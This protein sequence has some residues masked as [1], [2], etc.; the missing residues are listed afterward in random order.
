MAR[1]RETP[2]Q[3]RQ[4]EETERVAAIA[5]AQREQDQD[6]IA[7]LQRQALE[8]EA[9]TREG[10]E[11]A[12]QVRER[13]RAEAESRRL[14]EERRRRESLG[15]RVSGTVAQLGQSYDRAEDAFLRSATNTIVNTAKS[16]TFWVWF[17]TIVAFGTFFLWAKGYLKVTILFI[18]QALLFLSFVLLIF[19]GFRSG[20]K[21]KDSAA[22]FI[23][24]AFILWGIDLLPSTINIPFTNIAVFDIGRYIGP[25]YAGFKL[26]LSGILSTN[27]AAV[28]TSALVV[29]ALVLSMFLNLATKHLKKFVATLFLFIIINQI[30]NYYNILGLGRVFNVSYL[31]YIFLGIVILTFALAIFFRDKWKDDA[32]L[33]DYPTYLFMILV[34]SFFWINIGWIKNI[35]ALLH[36]IYILAFGFGYVARQEKENPAFWHLLIPAMLIADFYGYG[37]LWNSGVDVFRFIPIIVLFVL[38]YC[39]ARANST[40][41]LVSLFFVLGI[42]L[43]FTIQTLGVEAT[44][45]P[46]E[47]K[48][49]ADYKDFYTQFKDKLKDIIEGQL[50][51]A[52]AGLYRGSV[53]KNRYESLGVYFGNIRAADP[54]FYTDEP[55]TVWGSI[56]SKTYK[57]AVIINFSCYR[58]KDNRKITANK[59][60]PDIR[61]PIFTLEEVDTECTFLPKQPKDKD[62]IQPGA[63]TIT[64][65]AEYNFGT[66]AYLKTYF[67]DKERF[68]AN[69]REDIDHLTQFGIK[70]KNP[71]SVSTN[72]PVEIGIGAGPLVTVSEGYAV[73]PAVG[74]TLTNR[75]E[76]QDKDKRIIT[77]WDGK[78]KNITELILLTPPGITLGPEANLDKCNSKDPNEQLLCPCSMPFKSY[79]ANKCGNT[80]TLQVSN[81]CK[82]VCVTSYKDKKE[83]DT[84]NAECDEV[85]DRCI[86]ECDFL[87]KIDEGEG[88]S[89]E[90]YKGYALDV[91]SLK[92]KDL[93]KDIDKHRSFVCRFEPT[94]SVLGNTPITTR[95]FRVRA[96]YNYVVENSVTVNVEQLPVE[97]KSTLPDQLA[98]TVL[99]FK[100]GQDLWFD[101]FSPELIGAIASVES[102]GFKHCCQEKQSE[103]KSDGTYQKI[104]GVRCSSSDL[105]EC[106][107]SYL[108]TSGSSYGIMQIN[109]QGKNKNV[110]NNL[111][112]RYCNG[113][114]IKDYDC[115]VKV[116][117]AI[118]KNKF[119]TFKGGCAKFSGIRIA[120]STCKSNIPPNKRYS[121][122]TGIEA[123]LR[124]YNGWGC[125]DSGAVNGDVGYVEKVLNAMKTV[126]GIEIIDRGTLSGIAREGEGMVDASPSESDVQG[127]TSSTSPE[128]VSLD[129]TAS[130]NYYNNNKRVT[131]TWSDPGSSE[132]AKYSVV[133]YNYDSFNNELPP[134]PICEKTRGS[135]TYNCFDDN[136]FYVQGA[137]NINVYEIK[138]YINENKYAIKTVEARIV[139]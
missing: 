8:A 43:I 117:I 15:G 135:G 80:C 124:G 86:K 26:D 45:I 93:N 116:G 132:V 28:I 103:R 13:E 137:K 24:L 129:F 34:F 31:N 88:N 102:P 73:K 70:D 92:F 111:E 46:F 5:R 122:Y 105:K 59:I 41:A 77:K 106:D 22:I 115:N 40:Y 54:R 81:P 42:F 133:R 16:N 52:T 74:I 121:D 51:I 118:L 23:A 76:I 126:K 11:R 32:E 39:Y 62:A 68:R 136:Q 44:S 109:Y 95:Y 10:E 112:L 139:P 12:K 7:R 47:A 21:N 60:I 134:T 65:S 49:G 79:D 2:D 78:I 66:D 38:F 30:T 130:A 64:F 4:R 87:F 48:R 125:P 99:E 72:G 94:Q 97:A 58:W 75:K 33:A 36:V 98:K 61:F 6:A 89:N 20:I 1:A 18:L 50:D 67:I 82:E 131:I 104:K 108:V 37:L 17:I 27:W 19:F 83:S 138:A 53:E 90:K 120:C 35:R 14:E 128:I 57:D 63:N 127:Q 69:A 110:V 84:C 123:A 91:G 85:A 71:A 101:G 114:S 119:E 9:A 100:P 55:I 29:Y 3:R 25:P 96:R 107:F 113:K 56:R